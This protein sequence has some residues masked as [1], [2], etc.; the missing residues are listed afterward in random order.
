MKKILLYFCAVLLFSAQ[1]NAQSCTPGANF[2]DSTYGIWPDTTTNFPPAGINVAY[3]TDLNFKVPSEVTEE[4]TGGDEMLDVFIGA[5]IV[6][7]SVSDVIGLPA[8]FNYA[9]NNSGCE[10]LGGENGCA[11]VFGTAT[12][13]GVY[14]VTIAVDGVVYA[15]LFPGLPEAE[16]PVP[17]INFEGYKIVVG[18]AGTIEGFIEPLKVTPNPASEII[19]INGLSAYENSCIVIFNIEGKVIDQENQI[20][21]NNVDFDLK[22]LNKGV[23]FVKVLHTEG[24]ETVKFIKE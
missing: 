23:Y 12:E 18:T 10:Y 21:S 7:F 9:C 14:D 4:I 13:A 3:S 20:N 19:T 1:L 5:P 8:G 11:N 16:L 17:T 15:S 2:A 22:S 24:I 6:S